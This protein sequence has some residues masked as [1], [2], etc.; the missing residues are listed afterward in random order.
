[1]GRSVVLVRTD[2]PDLVLAARALVERVLAGAGLRCLVSD[3][4]LAVAVGLQVLGLRLSAWSL[5]GFDEQEAHEALRL[6]ASGEAVEFG[7]AGPFQ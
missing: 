6:A 5:W 7:V 1:L 4:P 2:P 3:A